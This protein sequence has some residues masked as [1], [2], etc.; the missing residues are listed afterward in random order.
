MAA[1]WS[2]RSPP[3]GTSP[4][5]GPS[6]RV[7]WYAAACEDGT[8]LGS[9]ARG[10]PKKLNS[11]GSQSSVSRSINMVRLAL[12]T[13]VMCWPPSTPPVRFH[14]SQLSV[15][16]KSAASFGGLTYTVDV[17]QNP[18][19]LAA[20]KVGGRRQPRPMPDDIAPAVAIKCGGDLVGAGVLPD[21]GIPVRLAC[22]GI[23]D[24][25]RLTLVGDPEPHQV[26]GAKAA[27]AKACWTTSGCAAR[28][29]ADRAPPILPSA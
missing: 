19:Q 23:P 17:L 1:C 3:I 7:R 9:I 26:G 14:N 10:I 12:V 18:L 21:D 11:S 24:D 2:P 6:A 27:L 16:P 15:V 4:P 25:R 5:N 28:F 8:M 22:Y 20:G 13:S 29:P